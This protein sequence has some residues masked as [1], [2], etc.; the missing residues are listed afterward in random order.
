MRLLFTI[1]H[2]VRPDAAD[3]P[4]HGS[5][6]ADVGPRT[7]ALTACLAALHQHFNAPPS[8]IHHARGTAHAFAPTTPYQLDVVV[9]TTGGCHLL[10]QLPVQPRYY[11]HQPTDAEPPL[12]GFAC[13]AALRERLGRY[14]YYCYLEDDLILHDPWL[15]LKLAWFNRCAGDDKLLQANRY[16]A[17]LNHL[18]PKVYVDGDLA[19]RVTAPFQDV[20]DAGPLSAEVMGVRLLFERTLNPHSGCFFLNARQMEQWARQPHFLDHDSRFIGP[21]ETAATLGI[22]RTFKIY[23]PAPANADFLEIQHFATG[24]LERLCLED[25]G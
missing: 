12:L 4:R 17:G 10:D 2:Y 23:R 8:F 14:D 13:H 11:T 9:C 1:P 19:E 22:M 18:V 15:F 25:R 24:Y 21:L 20:R 7:R 16:E 5:L 6:A 3:P